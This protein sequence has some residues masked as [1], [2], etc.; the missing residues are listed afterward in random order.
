MKIKMVLFDLDGTLLPMD[1]DVFAASYFG[2]IAK[3]LAGHGYQPS[4]LISAIQ[5]GTVAMVKN[6][7]S[8]TNEEVFWKTFTSVYGEKARDDEPYFES[9][10]LSRDGFDKVRESVGFTSKAAEVIALLKALGLRVALATNPLFPSIA[11]EKRIR[12][13]GLSTDDFELYTTYE[14]SHFCKPNLAYYEE[15]LKKLDLSPEECLMVGNDAFE[16]MIAEKLGMKVFLLTDCLINKKNI[17][18]SS[19]PAGGFDDLCEY[20]KKLSV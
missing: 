4:E 15:I 11:T 5:K 1:Q 14:N 8:A 7:G 20:I 3:A 10:Y 19:Y 13:A 16:D 17:D 18:I 9:F 12:W 2:G 6:D